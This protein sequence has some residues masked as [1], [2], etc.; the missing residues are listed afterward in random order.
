M[1]MQSEKTLLLHSSFVSGLR[2]LWLLP[3]KTSRYL[4]LCC[5]WAVAWSCN[6]TTLPFSVAGPSAPSWSLPPKSPFKSTAD[7]MPDSCS[8][9][10]SASPLGWSPNYLSSYKKQHNFVTVHIFSHIFPRAIHAV[11]RTSKM[12]L[13]VEDERQMTTVWGVASW[14][15]KLIFSLVKKKLKVNYKWKVE[16][17]IFYKI[18]AIEREKQQFLE[19]FFSYVLERTITLLYPPLS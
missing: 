11:T 14:Y 16:K 1:S 17:L 3:L 15:L 4:L 9:D 8:R 7:L 12:H 13:T 6:A 10:L 5:P 18:I 2:L 19:L